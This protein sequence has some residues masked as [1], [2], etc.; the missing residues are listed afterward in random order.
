[1][2]ERVTDFAGRSGIP[3]FF[4]LVGLLGLSACAPF[5]VSDSGP[6]R[7]PDGLDDIQ[8]PIPSEEPRSR[9]G[10]PE[11]YE[12]FGETYYV[13]DSAAG[14]DEEGI[15]SWYGKKFHGERTSSGEIY[16]MY[17]LTAA[18]TTLP[19]PTY[20][21]VTNLENDRSLVLRVNDRGPFAHNRIIDLSYAAAHRLGMADAGT[22]PVRVQALTGQSGQANI[23]DE[24][25]RIQVGAF[26]SA[27]NAQALKRRLESRGI[28]PIQLEQ[29][30]RGRRQVHRVQVGPISGEQEVEDLLKR[31]EDAGIHD[32]RLIRS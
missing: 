1:V 3:C 31:L 6:S 5:E 8:E 28:E 29:E 32:T 27:E 17:A 23:G 30:G 20:V 11:S 19:L 14:Y 21:R 18:H 2:T 12:V 25:V 4:A 22:A 13:L 16:D 15:A 7:A 10:N 26:G 24:P 9:Y